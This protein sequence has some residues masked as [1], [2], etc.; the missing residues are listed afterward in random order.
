MTITAWPFSSADTTESQFEAWAS[1][2]QETGVDGQPSDSAFKSTTPNTGMTTKVEAGF[3]LI[4]GTAVSSDAQ[5]TLTHDAASGTPRNDLIVLRRSLSLDS[6][7][8][9]II[10]GTP[11]ASPVDPA[12]TQTPGGVYDCRIARVRIGASTTSIDSSL[13]DDLRSFIALP[14][15]GW[16]TLTRPTAPKI[17]KLGFNY[18][19]LKLEFW[20]GTAWAKPGTDAGDLTG[21]VTRP[22]TGDH[23]GLLMGK[24]I[25][26]Q[27]ATP[28]PLAVGHVWIGW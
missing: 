22:T 15:Q 2:L 10:K 16:T 4:N 17:G 26:I 25:S 5:V 7:V 3:A 11:N 23:T 9:T 6:M 21:T 13:I 8:P 14:Y 18:T 28:T 27:Q 24:P 20:D 1:R 19:T 12:M